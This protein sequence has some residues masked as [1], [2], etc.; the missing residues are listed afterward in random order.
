MHTRPECETTIFKQKPPFA[1]VVIQSKKE[2]LESTL[3][4]IPVFSIL[5][6]RTR[7]IPK[8]SRG[9]PSNLVSRILTPDEMKSIFPFPIVIF[10]TALA[11]DSPE[12]LHSFP[13]CRAVTV[14][15][16][17][18]GTSH[19]FFTCSFRNRKSFPLNN[20]RIKRFWYNIIRP[21]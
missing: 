9:T 16:Y 14:P 7:K 5:R 8:K 17:Y 1:F 10:L 21:K 20:A 19:T 15:I 3:R 13:K 11:L 6:Y 18:R 4:R 12:F 2:Q